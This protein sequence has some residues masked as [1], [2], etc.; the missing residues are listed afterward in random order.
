MKIIELLKKLIASSVGENQQHGFNL[1]THRN[2]YAP[3]LN[4]REEYNS[5]SKLAKAYEIALDTRKFEIELYWKRAT[6]FWAITAVVLGAIGLL[7]SNAIKEE[8]LYAYSTL[9]FLQALSCIGFI[10]TRAW[11]YVNKGGKFWHENWEHQ[12]EL[13]EG[14]ILLPLY[15]SVLTKN[16][17]KGLVHLFSPSKVN[18]HLSSF[19]SHIFGAI[20]VSSIVAIY[21][22]TFLPIEIYLSKLSVPAIAALASTIL[23]IYTCIFWR[24][25]YVKARTTHTENPALNISLRR[26]HIVRKVD[27]PA[28]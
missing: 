1:D 16:T 20:C 25:M 27:L 11:R 13:I 19:F 7:F 5:K 8:N 17:Q 2:P 3:Y 10:V 22:K 12:V 24:W 28:D 21:S 6:Y 15:K 26:P 14:E 18:E 9:F 23:F 4:N